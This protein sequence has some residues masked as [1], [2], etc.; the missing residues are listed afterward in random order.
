MDAKTVLLVHDNQPQLVEL[1]TL[2][3]QGMCPDNQRD[4]FADG[5]ECCLPGLAG[6]LAAEPC[7]LHTHRLQP[8]GEAAQVL[9]GE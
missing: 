3:H 9:L 2:L 5:F 8:V 4:P 6:N 7:G 1:N